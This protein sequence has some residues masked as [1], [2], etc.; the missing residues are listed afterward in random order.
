[1]VTMYVVTAHISTKRLQ[2]FFMA[3]ELQSAENRSAGEE[4]T[5]KRN[6]S[7]D[8]EVSESWGYLHFEAY[9]GMCCP[10]ELLFTQIRRHGPIL[11]KKKMN[12]M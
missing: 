5:R 1:M 3:D 6:V 11:V 12:F 10:K 7:G 8:G 2:K 9:K 4:E